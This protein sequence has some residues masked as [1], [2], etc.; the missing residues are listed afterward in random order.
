MHY[1][2]HGDETHTY[3]YTLA[4]GRRYRVL[5]INEDRGIHAI[6]STIKTFASERSKR[7]KVLIIFD[8][9]T[10]QDESQAALR[11]IMEQYAATVSFVFCC[12]SLHTISDAIQSRCTLIRLPRKDGPQ[13]EEDDC[14]PID[15]LRDALK[16]KELFSLYDCVCSLTKNGWRGDLILKQL[17][18]YEPKLALYAS[19]ADR[20][21]IDGSNDTLQVYN[22]LVQY[23]NKKGK[24]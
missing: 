10:L 4:E 17:V 12:K 6:R 8:A 1:I 19:H 20:A 23:I 16:R 24:I 22:A 2:L 7:R 5:D 14:P 21:L 11:R 13:L 18:E 9:D 15:E 3:A